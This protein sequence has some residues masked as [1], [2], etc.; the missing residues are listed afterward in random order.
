MHR[1][2]G[3]SPS[4]A[5]ASSRGGASPIGRRFRTRR[6]IHWLRALITTATSEAAPLPNRA[7]H[8]VP[9]QFGLKRNKPTANIELFQHERRKQVQRC[10]ARAYIWFDGRI[11]RPILVRLKPYVA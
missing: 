7:D 6:D 9:G 5:S 8:V 10:R 2:A 4:A 1:R 11:C 3:P